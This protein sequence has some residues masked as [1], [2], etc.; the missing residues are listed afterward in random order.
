M[1]IA[2]GIVGDV[3]MG[4]VLAAHDVTAERGGA[5]GFDGGHD[6]LL[7]EAQTASFTGAIRRTVGAEDIRDL[8]H[9][10]RH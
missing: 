10:A 1:P 3:D 2:T 5:A 4:A 8:Q 9:R 6:A 7:A